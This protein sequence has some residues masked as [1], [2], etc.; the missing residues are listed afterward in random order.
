MVPVAVLGDEEDDVSLP[1]S[2]S[3]VDVVDTSSSITEGATEDIPD[4]VAPP[5]CGFTTGARGPRYKVRP[6]DRPGDNPTLPTRQETLLVL[7]P[8]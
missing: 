8:T 6:E 4:I 3:R 2:N 1:H 5:R 7:P